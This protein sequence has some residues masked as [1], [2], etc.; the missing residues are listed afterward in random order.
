MNTNALAQIVA[1]IL[2]WKPE[3]VEKKDWEWIAG[4][5]S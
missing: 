4:L 3:K 2:F 1:E 5:S